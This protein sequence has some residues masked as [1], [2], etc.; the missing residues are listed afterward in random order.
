MR[1]GRLTTRRDT[2]YEVV[3]Q[4][5]HYR[6][7]RYG[8]GAHAG[9]AGDPPRAPAH[10]HG[11]GLRRRA[12]SRA[13]SPPSSRRASIRWVVDFGAPEHEEGGMSRTLDDHVHAVVE[14]VPPRARRSRGD[15]HLA[16]TR[17]AGCSRIRW[18]RT[19]AARAS[20]RSSPSAA[21][22]TSTRTCPTSA[23]RSRRGRS[24]PC[25]PIVEPTL[26]RI[27]GLPG[28][29]TSLGFKLVSVRKEAAQLVDFVRKLHDRQAPGEA[30][31]AAALPRRRGL[32]GLAGAGVPQV[33]GRVHHPQPHAL[34]RVRHRGP[35]RHARRAALPGAQLR[36]RCATRSRAPAAVGPSRARPRTRRCSRS[37]SSPATSGWSWAP[38]RTASPGR[39]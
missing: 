13:P 2:P 35:H 33:R 18:P 28:V 17:R 19:S 15:L 25:A 1:L 39:P 4:G 10:G 7:R 14:G 38:R 37:T 8:D 31:G 6:L 20:P 3:H 9:P 27:E 12:R 29:I 24:R 36:R 30:R 16:A 32:R 21:R 34:G 11:R 26:T 5:R 22:S 23:P